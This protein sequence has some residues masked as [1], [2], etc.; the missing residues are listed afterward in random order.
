MIVLAVM[1][2]NKTEMYMNVI[3]AY[4]V[5][6]KIMTARFSKILGAM[7]VV[8]FLLA[9]CN[10]N[11][12]KENNSNNENALIGSWQTVEQQPTIF[13]FQK[14]NVLFRNF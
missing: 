5:F 4:S 11:T 2:I 8:Q 10:Q 7:V 14:E 6:H 13:N 12:V 3:H 1:R 9:G